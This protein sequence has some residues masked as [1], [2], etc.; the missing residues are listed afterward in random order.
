MSFS[1]MLIADRGDD[2]REVHGA[3][4]PQG[5]ARAARTGGLAAE[6]TRE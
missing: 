4:K 6:V 3:A 1:K 2:V 5:M